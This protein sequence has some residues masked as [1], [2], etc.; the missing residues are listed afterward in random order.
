MKIIKIQYDDEF[1]DEG[2]YTIT[3]WVDK[4]PPRYISLARD[5][6]ESPSIIYVELFDQKYGYETKNVTYKF[7]ENL[8]NLYLDKDFAFLDNHHHIQIFIND[9]DMFKVKQKLELI[10][11]V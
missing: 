9:A 8:L 4:E 5:E 6:E 3:F 10:F 2:L 11:D 7:K 1:E